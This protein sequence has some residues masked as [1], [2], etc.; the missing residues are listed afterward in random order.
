M[1]MA[2]EPSV[3]RPMT[4]Y[5]DVMAY[6]HG[7]NISLEDKASVGRQLLFEAKNASLANALN[8]LDHLS[9][10]CLDWDGYGGLPVSPK[11]IENLR[12]ALSVSRD[13]D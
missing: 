11:V 13:A 7:I 5:A 4:S 1:I 2:T 9:T 8:R 3:S 12:S 10:L 6:L